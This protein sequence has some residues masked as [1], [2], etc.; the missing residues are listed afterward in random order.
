MGNSLCKRNSRV[1]TNLARCCWQVYKWVVTVWLNVCFASSHI[2]KSDQA[3][4]DDGGDPKG[5]PRGRNSVATAQLV[6]LACL[7]LSLDQVSHPTSTEVYLQL[8]SLSPSS[9]DDPGGG[10]LPPAMEISNSC[11][12]S[13][14]TSVSQQ[15]Q[16]QQSQ[17]T[18]PSTNLAAVSSSGASNSSDLKYLHKK[19]K[20]IASASL[21]EVTSASESS[22]SGVAVV[23]S[24]A[25]SSNAV[26]APFEPVQR[27]P[28]SLTPS[29][30]C[31][32]QGVVVGNL[33]RSSVEVSEQQ[34]QQ[35]VQPIVDE[36]NYSSRLQLTPLSSVGGDHQNLQQQ[37]SNGASLNCANHISDSNSF[38]SSSNHIPREES[39]EFKPY[40]PSVNNN[41]A[42]NTSS[43]PSEKNQ[44]LSVSYEGANSAAL[45]YANGG[46]VGSEVV[47]TSATATTAPGRYVCPYCSMNCSKPSVLQKHIRRHTNERP[48]RCDPCGIAFKTKSNLYKH[49]RWVSVISWISLVWSAI[50]LCICIAVFGVDFRSKLSIRKNLFLS[51]YKE[52]F[53]IWNI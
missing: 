32:K 27:P 12:E 19:F 22:S 34:Q 9:A 50:V 4:P 35:R 37:H 21:G 46:P 31:A 38:I 48:F 7:D 39:E 33:V 25:I 36:T 47:S 45:F 14:I 43:D 5:G 53:I 15:Q 13:K 51:T 52:V 1:R 40:Y 28:S 23:P 6:G 18:K 20:R 16:Q 2:V 8:V 3:W 10:A 29:P 26:V 17:N 11:S 30:T 41:S 42:F 24:T 44:P 49:C